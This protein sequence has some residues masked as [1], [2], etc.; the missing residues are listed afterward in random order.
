MN[1]K[2]KVNQ[3]ILPLKT[4]PVY[5]TPE[6][7]TLMSIALNHPDG[8]AWIYN[9]YIQTEVKMPGSNCLL[10]FVNLYSKQNTNNLI[11][12]TTLERELVLDFIMQL[13]N[14]SIACS[15]YIALNVDTYYIPAYENYNEKHYFHNLLIY[16]FDQDNYHIADFFDYRKYSRT[17]C[18]KYE[19][20]KAIIE[21]KNL[22]N[23]ISGSN[24]KLITL[25][26]ERYS[27]SIELCLNFLIDYLNSNNSYNR[28]V[29]T[30]D[31]KCIEDNFVYGIKIYD[32]IKDEIKDLLGNNLD[33]FYIIS[34]LLYKH[35]VLMRMRINYLFENKF[36]DNFDKLDSLFS[37]IEGKCLLIR[38]LTI[39]QQFKK[40]KNYDEI[41][42]LKLLDDVKENDI[43]ATTELINQLKHIR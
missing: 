9:N 1:T 17:I 15:N 6:T 32:A 5:T 3:I 12:M 29:V 21:Y 33:R 27:F 16:G 36:I 34:D 42:F 24:I 19:L 20:H 13:I 22:N 41:K 10:S 14:N 37:M 31:Y 25:S 4:S 28:V 23:S 2:D 40:A 26:K 8:Y 39:K 43:I 11:S 35:K 38:N 30:N 7:V 18:T